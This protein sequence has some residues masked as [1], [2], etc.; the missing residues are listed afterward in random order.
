MI[1][2]KSSGSELNPPELTCE[3][4]SS[5]LLQMTS[6]NCSDTKVSSGREYSFL[7]NTTPPFLCVFRGSAAYGTNISSLAASVLKQMYTELLR[8]T[9]SPFTR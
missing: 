4:K 5:T 6:P 7:F 1:S 9:S 8:V 3:P 2:S